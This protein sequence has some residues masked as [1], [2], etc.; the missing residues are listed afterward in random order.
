LAELGGLTKDGA[1]PF[2]A[3]LSDNNG[4]EI[5]SAV[6]RLHPNASPELQAGYMLPGGPMLAINFEALSSGL[7]SAIAKDEAGQPIAG[8]PSVWS[9]TSVGGEALGLVDNMGD[10]T[11]CENWHS[12][13][14]EHVGER[15]IATQAQPSWT[16]IAPVQHCSTPSQLYCFQAG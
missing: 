10:P 2:H 15:G 13:T 5:S 7:M 14:F 6:D 1:P 11:S 9:N 3:W 8:T 12:A 4:T 16:Q